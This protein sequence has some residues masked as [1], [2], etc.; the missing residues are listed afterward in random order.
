MSSARPS[1]I[2]RFLRPV[3]RWVWSNPARRGRKLL[4]FAETEADGGRDLARAAELTNDAL[5]RRLYLRHAADERRH[6][7]LFRH[8]G[9]ALLVSLAE[10]GASVLDAAW[11]A[12]GERGLDDLHVDR[13]SDETLLA[14]LHL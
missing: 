14:F 7:D 13:E 12:P 8:R 6:A 1:S 3:H 4:R 11:I 5:L 10:Q 9:K 2:D